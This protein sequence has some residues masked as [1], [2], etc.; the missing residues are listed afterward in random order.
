MVVFHSN[1]CNFLFAVYYVAEMKTIMSKT[2]LPVFAQ[3]FYCGNKE[4][5]LTLNA[6]KKSQ[7]LYILPF[8][9]TQTTLYNMLTCGAHTFLRSMQIIGYNLGLD[10]QALIPSIQGLPV[11]TLYCEFSILKTWFKKYTLYI[12]IN[13]DIDLL[14]VYLLA[15]PY[16]IIALFFFCWTSGG[17]GGDPRRGTVT[18][19]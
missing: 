13:F 6:W 18:L 2:V 10:T 19:S 17:T 3:H 4:C 5:L 9:S 11:L 15:L 16:V 12:F 8:I 14:Y 1:Y 7:S